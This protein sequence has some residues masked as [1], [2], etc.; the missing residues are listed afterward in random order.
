[1]WL[2]KAIKKDRDTKP[3]FREIEK[4]IA[5]YSDPTDINW[6]GSFW[7]VNISRFFKPNIIKYL[8]IFCLF[9]I[10]NVTLFLLPPGFKLSILEDWT[11][12]GISISVPILVLGITLA[13]VA[14][15]LSEASQFAS[16]YLKDSCKISIVV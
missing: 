9:T 11:R 16:D 15:S 4:L 1:M 6:G 2:S 12:L 13:N 8:I 14:K 7:T 10:A 5:T 3:T